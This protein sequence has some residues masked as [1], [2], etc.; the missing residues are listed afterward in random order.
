MYF[1]PIDIAVHSQPYKYHG[2]MRWHSVDGVVERGYL[3]RLNGNSLPGVLSLCRST[4]FSLRHCIPGEIN[5]HQRENIGMYP[6]EESEWLVFDVLM[7]LIRPCICTWLIAVSLI[8]IWSYSFHH[9][10]DTKTYVPLYKSSSR[11]TL[12]S[13]ACVT[14]PY[15]STNIF[16]GIFPGP[17]LAEDGYEFLSPVDSSP[18]IPAQNDYGLHHMIGNAWEWVEDWFT[19]VWS[20]IDYRALE[21]WLICRSTLLCWYVTNY[22]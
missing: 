15:L 9:H 2:M 21:R 14:V 5:S 20:I 13:P 7:C 19:K 10:D 3:P 6:E 17:N 1:F 4:T 18:A 16:Q 22:C 12:P 8:F 11:L